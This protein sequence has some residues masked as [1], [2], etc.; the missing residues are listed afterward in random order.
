[1][2]W[3]GRCRPLARACGFDS[4]LTQGLR[5]RPRLIACRSLARVALLRRELRLRCA[6]GRARRCGSSGSHS[7]NRIK[8]LVERPLL[9]VLEKFVARAQIERGQT[10]CP[11]G[12]VLMS[13]R[14]PKSR[15]WFTC[16]MM[17]LAHSSKSWVLQILNQV[18]SCQ[19]GCF[20][21]LLVLEAGVESRKF[22]SG[23]NYSLVCSQ[24]LQYAFCRIECVLRP[25]FAV[26]MTDLELNH[27]ASYRSQRWRKEECQYFNLRSV[28]F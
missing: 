18:H 6:C 9:R 16:L 10:D 27:R 26:P 1:M 19:N 13:V 12:S 14:I 3:P 17:N 2:L 22:L 11:F 25:K 5:T 24:F 20:K 28:A 15:L 8:P 21:V 23:R 7:N 4:R